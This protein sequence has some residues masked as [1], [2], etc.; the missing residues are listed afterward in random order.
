MA[1]PLVIN[2]AQAV[3]LETLAEHLEDAWLDGITDGLVEI[4]P[5]MLRYDQLTELQRQETKQ[6]WMAAFAGALLIFGVDGHIDGGGGTPG[7]PGPTGPAGA[8][9]INGT[10][11]TNGIPTA[12]AA[13]GASPN[14]SGATLSGS[15]LNLEPADNTHP[16][17]LTATSQTI[18]GAKTISAVLTST[19]AAAPA[20]MTG[21]S[22]YYGSTDAV[23]LTSQAA[24]GP[25]AFAAI[26]D[27]TTAWANT[28]ATLLS[29]RTNNVEKAFI[30]RDGSVFSS[31][32]VYG[33]AHRGAGSSG[34][35]LVGSQ[36][37]EPNTYTRVAAYQ[38][39][40]NASS[41]IVS[42]GDTYGA[43]GSGYV[44]KA[45]ISYDGSFTTPA[46]FTGT[47]AM[48]GAVTIQS[49]PNQLWLDA[50][51]GLYLGHGTTTPV[52][53]NATVTNTGSY[54][55]SQT[56]GGAATA[57]YA[58]GA[59][60]G[61][62]QAANMVRLL[63]GAAD[64]NTAVA[65]AIDSANAFVTTGAK[66]LSVRNSGVEKLYVG[67]DGRLVANG[68]ISG[69][70]LSGTNTGDV[71]LTAV[72]AAPSANGATLSGQ[73]LTLQPADN[74]HP[75]V[76][77]SGTQTIGGVKTFTLAP[78]SVG[79]TLN[80][81]SA[82]ST[83]GQGLEFPNGGGSW[84]V[85]KSAVGAG[86]DLEINSFGVTHA[87]F[88]YST[89]IV[90][91]PFGTTTAQTS[92]AKIFNSS[93]VSGSDAVKLL[94][95]AHLNF[96]TGDTN[97]FLYRKSA[98]IIGTDGGF[99]IGDAAGSLQVRRAGNQFFVADPATAIMSV[100][101]GSGGGQINT[102]TLQI[103][104]TTGGVPSF[105]FRIPGNG[106][107]AMDT[108]GAYFAKSPVFTA[109]IPYLRAEADSND[110][111]SIGGG[112]LTGGSIS[113]HVSNSTSGYVPMVQ[114]VESI[115]PASGSGKFSAL[116]INPTING[117]SSSSA[118]SLAIASKTNTLTGGRVFLIDAGVTT[119]DY[120]TGYSSMFSVES[121]GMIESQAISGTN[122][123]RILDGAFLNFSTADGG[124][125]LYRNQTDTVAS[126][127]NFKVGKC[128]LAAAASPL[129][130][131][132]LTVDGDMR[133]GYLKIT[134]DYRAFTAAAVTQTLPVATLP[135]RCRVTSVIAD[136]TTHYDGLRPTLNLEVG[137]VGTNGA[138]ITSHDVITAAVTKGL[139]D[140]DL[141]TNLQ[142]A[143]AVQGGWIVSWTGATNLTVTMTNTFPENLG[144][145]AATRMSQ[146]V[147]VIYVTYDVL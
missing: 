30:T 56:T 71:T 110:V 147:T 104:G 43:N 48:G 69:S 74:T 143:N 62:F 42:F 142:R 124:A 35:N 90:S 145:G 15:T 47:I 89:G 120:G 93:Q 79:L 84:F 113:N 19:V 100:D 51:G 103:G 146:G 46:L 59:T 68:A 107:L 44:E 132:D 127:S 97:A 102:N 137:V 136:T 20:F 118:T 1:S 95:G 40:V 14:A 60:S 130:G 85:N 7:P 4:V 49:N 126:L 23:R 53:A 39:L 73:A 50:P 115:T 88:S 70:N 64:S 45:Y 65:T 18:G 54:F 140:G 92:A 78:V 99:Y 87:T 133:R 80:P 8:D 11:G 29:L 135:A 61:A 63:A 37:S 2:P 91:F 75:G 24:D 125:I 17:V 10:N 131:L 141:G 34:A 111:I 98:N 38:A 139:A 86:S 58:S 41:R 25:S 105:I 52:F 6:V 31:A 3:S 123:L 117:V 96:S 119:T 12:L 116:E 57:F 112:R 21:V 67:L 128:E 32:S 28:A 26:I 27:T 121:T 134:L 138:L 66:L 114:V 94:D 76:V 13:V 36:V 9:G 77:T 16:G 72:G 81:T 144:T 106:L 101:T 122:A 108:F 5:P 109:H 82:P 129:T 33:T 55:E 22:G 83:A